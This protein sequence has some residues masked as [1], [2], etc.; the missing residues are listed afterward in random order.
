M[1][2]IDPECHEKVLASLSPDGIQLFNQ[3]HKAQNQALEDNSG[4]R[5][6]NAAS[7]S[8]LDRDYLYKKKVG[9]SLQH[10]VISINGIIFNAAQGNT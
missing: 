6:D 3:C 7:V 1:Q 10:P 4:A 5:Y 9:K 2:A 8:F